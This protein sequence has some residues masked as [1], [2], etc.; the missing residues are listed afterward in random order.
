MLENVREDLRHKVAWRGFAPTLVSSVRVLGSEGSL[1]QLLYRAMRF[2]QTRGLRLPALLI[3]RLNAH[4]GHVII[5]RD[6]D[7]GPGFI[8]LHG[9][10][11]VIDTGV[12]AGKN[13][14]LQDEVT[15]GELRGESPVLG[16]NV[17]VGAGA[18][19]IGPVRVGNDVRIGANAVV[20][21]DL[22]DGATAAGAPACV[23]RIY[24][25]PVTLGGAPR[26]PVH[27]EGRAAMT[28]PAPQRPAP[29][30]P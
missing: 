8:L 22:P 28:Q 15:L 24:G 30:D 16:D 21:R 9:T 5:G 20:T 10:G 2:C 26:S 14:V 27:D 13:L 25:E 18:R 1:G 3:Y 6:A 4:V 19:V 17:F 23:I 29:P 12:K 7:I 11:I